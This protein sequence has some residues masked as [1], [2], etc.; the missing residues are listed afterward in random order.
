MLEK[1]TDAG[2]GRD[3]DGEERPTAVE[4]GGDGEGLSQSPMRVLSAGRE[5]APKIIIL[6][7]KNSI[8][9]FLKKVAFPIHGNTQ[10][11]RNYGNPSQKINK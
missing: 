10:T 6:F 1:T 5:A 9:L 4:G 3:D 11:Q 8:F 2:R 7:P